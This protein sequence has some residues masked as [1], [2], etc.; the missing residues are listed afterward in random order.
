MGSTKLNDWMQVIGIFA[1][2]ASII[3][4]GLQMRL[5]RDIARV[6]IYQSRASTTAEVLASLASSPDAMAAIIKSSVG[7]PITAQ[8]TWLGG[9]QLNSVFTLTDNSLYQYQEGF[10][11]EDH[12]LSVRRTVKN[13][14]SNNQFVRDYVEGSLDN[15]RPALRDELIGIMREI[16]ERTEN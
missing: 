11:P 14:I 12:W 15:Y 2:V 13:V 5:D 8:D 6:M 4:V 10:L 9:F 3:F 1:L 16:D 7:D